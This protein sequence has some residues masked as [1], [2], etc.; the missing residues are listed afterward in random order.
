MV[1]NHRP[2]EYDF[3]VEYVRGKDNV[4]ADALSRIEISSSE[5]NAKIESS[6]YVVTRGQ[7]RK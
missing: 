4:T 5:L 7:A 3:P 2:L 6:T 1:R